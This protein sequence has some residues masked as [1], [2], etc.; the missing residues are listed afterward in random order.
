MLR[1]F[2]AFRIRWR[3]VHHISLGAVGLI[4]IAACF[5]LGVILR[6]AMGPVAL[7]PFSDR[8][9][10]S[11][12]HALPGLAIR[13]DEAAL[14]W[15]REEG[16]VNIIIV[17]TRIFDS[18]GRIVAQA[19]KAEIGLAAMPFVTGHIEVRRIDLVGVQ[20][21]LVHAKNG[22]LRL[23]IEKDRTSA[24]V[25]DRIREAIEKSGNGPSTLD[26]FAVS[27]ARLAFYDEQTGLFLVAPDAEIEVGNELAGASR[28]L[29]A[30]VNA[31]V[32]VTGQPAHVT[33][34]VS[35]PHA[36]KD[37]KADLGVTGLELTA[38]ARN[39]AT[40]AFLQPF[41]LRA[42]LSA[43]FVVKQGTQLKSADLDVSATG[44]IGGFG[45]PLKVRNVSL[46]GRYDGETKR[47][48]I[49][50]ATLKGDSVGA[51]AQGLANITLAADGT[52]A[53]ANLDI[54]ADKIFFPM[55]S[56]KAPTTLGGFGLRGTYTAQDRTFAIDR[57]SLNGALSGTLQ[58]RVVLL[59]NQ[60]PAI[61]A[62]GTIDPLSVRD[63]V[64]YWPPT[65]AAGA[66]SWVD[67]NVRAGRIGPVAVTANIAA[68]QLSA[69]ALPD[70]ALKVALPIKDA[71]VVYVKGMTLLTNANAQGVLT[72]DTFS[73][74]VT[75]ARVG[76]LAVQKAKVVIPELHKHGTAGDISATIQGRVRDL[77]K[78]LDEKPLQYPTR[79]HINTSETAGT[80][81]ADGTFHVPMVKNV[82]IDQIPIRVKAL[83]KGLAL[84]LG[85]DTKLSNGDVTFNVDNAHLHAQ[86][87]VNYGPAPVTVDWNEIFSS[88][89]DITTRLNV[90]GT[91]DEQARAALKLK[92]GDFFTGPVGVNAN[93][94]GHQGKMR[95]V[96]VTVDLT[97]ATISFDTISYRKPPGTAASAQVV[98]RLDQKGAISAADLTLSGAGLS[99]QGTL[100]FAADGSLS[101]AELPALRAGSANDFA[102]TY[103]EGP[104]GADIFIRGHSVDGTALGRRDNTSASAKQESTTR[105]HILARVDRMQLKEN[106]VLSPFNAEA[107]VVGSRFQMLSLTTG[108]SKGDSVSASIVPAADGRHVTVNASD[109]GALLK[110]VFG[111]D[112]ISGG[113]LTVAAKMPPLNA[114]GGPDFAGTLTIRDFKIEN[115]PF[116]ARLFSA[117]SLG[118]L[119]DLMRGSG[120]VIDKLEMP[121]S[122]ANDVVNIRDAHAAGPS[123]GL[124]GDGYIDRRNSTIDLKGA[125]AP[126]Y[127]IN[128]VLGAIPLVGNVLVSKQGEGIVGV[129]YEASGS[130]DEPKISVNPLSMLTPGIFRRIFEGRVPTAPSQA[131]KTSP[132]PA[133][134]PH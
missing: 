94:Q 52:F 102:L 78:I 51:H 77:L 44:I 13:Y 42:D 67:Q 69:P 5:V 32:E 101:R 122:A 113:R 66:R 56:A 26:K 36:G 120:I 24:D 46:L 80:V 127:G 48:L 58:G 33:A 98:A 31:N 76:P 107:T 75:S 109:A 108:M 34:K 54:T 53:S 110:G 59:Q 85:Q 121:F 123:V 97:P 72:G 41:D 129:T 128:S 70:Q 27:K 18:A 89:S 106:T 21:T 65:V 61:Q 96:Q 116:F 91:L 39:A 86:G 118:G 112:N 6:L 8:L 45:S 68:G 22:A 126:L 2:R 11:V 124:S 4:A 19:P 117:G 62:S 17:G 132:A 30:N 40:F 9:R 93:L 92:L 111:L 23:G 88:R 133:P 81:V 71:S 20:L 104:N 130:L 74:D 125:V 7:G 105:Y 1:R 57:L 25:L 115:Q 79:F 95:A 49:E 64:H 63:L 73:V 37:L 82:G 87:T 103:T 50:D 90:R 100:S 83:T 119:L 38:L 16:R 84:S 134:A 3:H 55:A 10:D 114:K 15:S 43:S 47:L 60:S 35:F 131:N 99:A 29:V 28:H 14:E 12:L